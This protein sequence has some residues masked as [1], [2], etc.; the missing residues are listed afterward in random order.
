MEDL[1]LI[2]VAVYLHVHTSDWTIVQNLL[3]L[4]PLAKG[5]SVHL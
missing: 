4:C 1:L 3:T 2:L 5:S